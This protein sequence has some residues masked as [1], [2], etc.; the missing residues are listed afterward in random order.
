M[1]KSCKTSPAK[2]V[3]PRRGAVKSVW[4]SRSVLV[5]GVVLLAASM[6]TAAPA[7]GQDELGGLDIF[8]GGVK[9]GNFGG[10]AVGDAK[11]AANY[12]LSESGRGRL[13]VGVDISHGWHIYSLTQKPGGPFKTTLKVNS[14]KSVELL[15]PFTPSESPAVH[16]SDIYN[17]LKIEEHE[18]TVTFA[19]P[20]RLPAGFNGP[21]EVGVDCQLCKNGNGA[22]IPITR[23]LT[24]KLVDASAQVGAPMAKPAVAAK[25]FRDGNYVVEWSGSITP[26]EIKPGSRGVMKFTAKP[27]SS[28]EKFH[29][30]R[31]MVDDSES[32]TNFV[33]T[34]KSGLKVGAPESSKPVVKHDPGQDLPALF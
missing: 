10:E 14:P 23:T 3:V 34:R 9:L 32:S 25:P 15:A 22:C 18:G 33:L 8:P 28:P 20:I 26:S 4:T 17:G 21:I 2:A 5:A 31:A 16:V 13:E 30:Y 6:I 19:A 7:T 24:A 12:S 11:W 27:D 1:L 29:V